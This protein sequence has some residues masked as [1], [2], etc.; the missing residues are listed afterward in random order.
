M[1]IYNIYLKCHIQGNPFLKYTQMK[2]CLIISHRSTTYVVQIESI[3]NESEQRIPSHS[4]MLYG[5]EAKVNWRELCGG[6]KYPVK[7]GKVASKGCPHPPE[8]VQHTN[9]VL[10]VAQFTVKLIS[11]QRHCVESCECSWVQV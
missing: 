3:H 9:I 5:T 6:S 10:E 2:H 11:Q 4:L 1:F 8:I 7:W